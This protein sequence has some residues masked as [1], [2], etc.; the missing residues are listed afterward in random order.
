V[1][2]RLSTQHSKQVEPFETESMASDSTSVV[3]GGANRVHSMKADNYYDYQRPEVLEM[4][5]VSATKI[6]DIGCGAGWLGKQ[7]KRRQNAVVWG[8]EIIESAAKLAL[9]RLDR[10][11]NSSVEQALDD[12]PPRS[13]DCI[14][15]ADVLE[16][17]IDPWSTLVRLRE[18]LVDGGTV[19]ASIPNV[20]HWSVLKNLL[21]GS[22]TYAYEGLLDRTHLR[23]FTRKSARALFEN[24]GL[25]IIKVEATRRGTEQPPA[26]LLEVLGDANLDVSGL[27]EDS[28]VFQFLILAQQP[29]AR[30]DDPKVAV[31]VLN[32]NGQRDT[33]ECI[34][35]LRELEYKDYDIIVVDNGSTDDSVRA[36]RSIFPNVT[37]LE[38]H[39]NLGYTGGNNAGIRHAIRVGAKY[40][41]VLNNDTVVHRSILR[42]LIDASQARPD[43]GLYGPAIY[44]YFEKDQLLTIGMISR[45][46]CP[47]EFME[48]SLEGAAYQEVETL[49]GCGMLIKR[50]VFERIG[51]F[52]ESFFL[53]WEELDFC[54]R[55][56]E[57]GFRCLAVPDALMWHKVSASFGGTASPLLRY[58]HTRNRLLWG[59]R[60][61]PLKALI[62]LHL[63]SWRTLRRILWPPFSLPQTGAPLAKRVLWTI[64]SWLKSVKRNV[65][66][67]TNRADLIGL[68]DYYLGRLGD[69][70]AAVRKLGKS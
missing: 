25:K 69:C 36:I 53:C 23:F 4:V 10:V 7:I 54:M 50:E 46:F 65:S 29:A 59:K 9:E 51:Y 27:A 13:L 5:P 44:S 14:I 26:E 56:T 18:K 20:Q 41:F 33:V 40:V 70:P 42:K 22:W 47:F 67:P 17:L 28:Q 49:V 55:A 64:L 48:A 63:E 12:I 68:R 2:L 43:A 30:L 58:F 34:E 62:Q 66:I 8:I 37:L 61:L 60:H 21:E 3:R 38:T 39:K 19:V 1:L 57:A 24:A 31:V 6:L 52:E 32:W 45:L 16:H 35:S 15:L 11:W